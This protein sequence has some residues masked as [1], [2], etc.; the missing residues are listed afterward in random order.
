MN[1]RFL[2]PA[3]LLICLCLIVAGC[4]PK[5]PGATPPGDESK[6]L[7]WPSQAEVVSL[8]DEVILKL[9]EGK[10]NVDEAI[11]QIKE[12]IPKPPG[13]PSRPIEYIVPWGEGGGSDMYARHIGSDASKIMG[14]PVIFNNMPG[15]GGEVGLAYLLTQPADGYTIYGAIAN[16]VINDA[17]GTQPHS[18]TRDVEFIIR[19][20]GATELFW[21]RQDSQFKTW[22]DMISFAKSNPG[23]VKVCGAGVM[24]DD[25][26]RIAYINRELGVELVYVPYDAV[27]TRVSSLLGGHVDVMHETAGTVIDLFHAKQIRP[28]AVGG[29][30]RFVDLD[31]DVPCTEELGLKLPI[32]RWRGIVTVKGVPSEIVDYLHNVFYAA[33][34]LPYYR[35]YEKKFF[36]HLARG[37]LSSA[38]FKNYCENEK[39]AVE[40]LLKEL[41]YKK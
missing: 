38:D 23:K 41:G 37:Y 8:I 26:L 40:V 3:S 7:S 20:Q 10:I 34:Q 13:Y 25:E 31:P 33:S 5:S 12:V 18:F 1:H 15:G 22:E 30:A 14:V 27:G 29:P 4:S 24:G 36:Q 17:A 32:G 11:A 35:E 6:Q 2:L 9:N 28:L 39:N 16:Q 21:V 19:N